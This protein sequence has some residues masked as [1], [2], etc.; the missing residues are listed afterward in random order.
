MCC[1]FQ[2]Y[3]SH[4]SWYKHHECLLLSEAQYATGIFCAQ[5]C[6][7]SIIISGKSMSWL[8]M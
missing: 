8:T 7:F 5:E 2:L 3:Y 4:G 1:Q 6:A